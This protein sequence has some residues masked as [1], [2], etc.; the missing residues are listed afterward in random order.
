MFSH[1]LTRYRH[2]FLSA[3]LIFSAACA[4]LMFRVNINTDMTLY[5]PDDSPMKAGLGILQQNF[6]LSPDMAG[7][8]V[9][10]MT[11]DQ[12]DEEK[13]DMRYQL[14]QMPEVGGVNILENN[15]HTLYELNVDKSIDQVD[16]GRTIASQYSKI[17][18]VETS[19]DGSTADAPMLLGGVALLLL[20]LVAMC[21]SWLEP[22]LFLATTGIAVLLNTG[23]NALL[24]SVSNTTNSIAAIL[25]LVLSMDYSI[26]LLNRYRQERA[27]NPDSIQAMQCAVRRAA[28]SVLSSALTTIVGL[29][30]L[31]FM[32]L[33]IGADLGIV[34]SKGVAFSLL[35]NFTV[36]PSLI[37]IF[38]RGIQRSQKP[39]LTLPTQHLARFSM[40]YRI[41]LSVFFVIL[42]VGAYILHNQTPIAFLNAQASQINDYFP[43][44][45]PVVLIYDNQDEANL[46]Q[47][48]DSVTA[49]PGVEMAL[50]YPSL[51]LR[52]Y[53]APQMVVA[54]QDMA[55]MASMADSAISDL[56]TDLL[57]VD[58]LRLVYFAAHGQPV[59]TL[60]FNQLASFILSQA[61]DPTSIVASQMSPEMKQKLALL[62]DFRQ[63]D[64]LAQE[65][66]LVDSTEAEVELIAEAFDITVE[67]AEPETPQ[68]AVQPVTQAKPKAYSPLTDTTKLRH[69]LNAEQ[70]AAFLGTDAG[71]AKM[72]YRLAKAPNNLMT[73][74]QFVHFLTDDIL[75]RKALAAMISSEQRQQ[76]IALRATIDSANNARPT[77]TQEPA[78]A[79]SEKPAVDKPVASD[80]PAVDN[81]PAPIQPQ[82]PAVTPEPD[83]TLALLDEMMSGSRRYTA[84]QMADNFT[85]M[86][87]PVSPA[88]MELLYLYYGGA[89]RY[90]DTWTMSLNDMI[91]FLGDS[92]MADP[93]FSGFIT[94][95]MRQGFANVRATI[96][97]K[98]GMM[99]SADKSIAMIITNLATESD[100]TY[101]F[102]SRYNDLC[103]RMLP[104]THYSIGESVMLNEMKN[105][106]RH[107]ML[108]VTILTILAIFLIV[109]VTFRS[110]LIALLL[111]T[112]VMTGVFV[113]VAVSAVGGG[114]LLY[115][116][117]LVVQ[118]ILMGAAIDYG[119]LFSNYYREQRATHSVPDALHAS[120]QGSI[121]T[122]LTSGLIL[123]LVPGAMSFLVADPTVSSIVRSISIGALATVLLILF[124]LPSLLALCDRFIIKISP[125]KL[126]K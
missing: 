105:S 114:S 18:A 119:I 96:H 125:K 41:P 83:S 84:R 79:T 13:V 118:S 88:L 76:L 94:N 124:V 44:K 43:K 97:D 24:P 110:L 61:K 20:V 2:W 74:I 58:L 28:P 47:F 63:L 12:T 67:D 87:E 19:Q 104:H 116:A 32:K 121:H 60:N 82:Q 38:E 66:L 78:L 80:K 25:Q 73:P 71:Q 89:N 107:E 69:P 117:Y 9:R 85:A 31:I 34:L 4:I 16:L 106:F 109:A 90:N 5:L 100:S 8:S 91:S 50:S 57:S 11:L 81:T 103:Q 72:V 26:I 93:R 23:T 59:G 49:L 27:S 6:G 29:M 56:P 111:V 17:Q 92:V 126:N 3:T 35:C 55:S 46:P 39:V 68:P 54:I 99:R 42:L 33:K 7:A 15:E 21:P 75:K 101:D 108:L 86:G 95:D 62:D 45:N 40:H 37:I 53:T 52:Q 30:M 102:L 22:V 51:M 115:M 70:M 113:D 123:I 122:I 120:Y 36:L 77:I 10:V 64:N 112:T 14:S 98:L 1:T 65:D 48:I